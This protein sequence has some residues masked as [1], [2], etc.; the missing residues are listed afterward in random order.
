MK[1][2]QGTGFTRGS[3]GQTCRPR[4]H[5][6]GSYCAIPSYVPRFATAEDCLSKCEAWNDCVCGVAAQVGGTYFCHLFTRFNEPVSAQ[7]CKTVLRHDAFAGAYHPFGKLEC[8]DEFQFGDADNSQVLSTRRNNWKF[9]EGCSATECTGCRTRRSWTQMSAS[10]RKQYIDTILTIRSGSAGT[11]IQTRYNQLI[12]DHK[13]NFNTG[14][15]FA[16]NF[17]AW[18]RWYVLQMENILREVEPCITI[19]F[20]AW[21]MDANNPNLW[22]N[23]YPMWGPNNYELGSVT[24]PEACVPDSPFGPGFTMTDGVSCLT[25]DQANNFGAL[26]DLADI[27]FNLNFYSSPTQFVAF[28]SKING[29]HGA[30]HCNVGGSFCLPNSAE[31]PE[32]FLHHA[33]VDRMWS[34]WQEKGAAFVEAYGSGFNSP[35]I[36]TS[37]K[38]PAE[39]AHLNNQDGGTCVQYEGVVGGLRRNLLGNSHHDYNIVSN[40]VDDL[41]SDLNF[42]KSLSH[43]S[44]LSVEGFR[45]WVLNNLN[46]TQFSPQ[47]RMDIADNEVKQSGLEAYIADR[48]V[49]TT[50]DPQT[51]TSLGCAA[52]TRIA[53]VTCSSVKETLQS[54]P[55]WSSNLQ[56]FQDNLGDLDHYVTP[57]ATLMS[58][59]VCHKDEGHHHVILEECSAHTP[60]SCDRL[61]KSQDGCVA[62]TIDVNSNNGCCMT[63]AATPTV[64]T[65]LDNDCCECYIMDKHL[66]EI[67]TTSGPSCT[68]DSF[69][70]F[71]QSDLQGFC[72]AKEHGFLASSLGSFASCISEIS[73]W[74]DGNCSTGDCSSCVQGFQ[75]AGGC[76][77]MADENCDLDSKI[78]P[79]C[80]Q[81]ALPATQSCGSGCSTDAPNEISITNQGNSDNGLYTLSAYDIM[82][83]KTAYKHFRTMSYLNCCEATGKWG[84]TKYGFTACDADFTYW[85]LD[86]SGCSV[87]DLVD[88]LNAAEQQTTTTPPGCTLTAPNEVSI[89]N[90]GS[91]NGVYSLQEYDVMPGKVAFKHFRTESRLNCCESTGKWGLTKYGFT[92][93]DAS[94]TYWLLDTN[95]CSVC[96][97]VDALNAAEQQTT[98]LAV[99]SQ[100]PVAGCS[101]T[102]PNEVTVSNQWR[103]DNGVYTLQPYDV[104]PGKPAYKHFRTQSFLNCCETTGKWGLTKYGYTAC[105]AEYT[106]WHLDTASCSVCDLN[107]ALNGENQP[108]TQEPA[109]TFTRS[110]V[111]K[112]CRPKHQTSGSYC[113]LPSRAVKLSSAE[114]CLSKCEA[115][116]ECVCGVAVSWK[117]GEYLCN[118]FTDSNDPPSALTCK[119]VL[120]ADAFPGATKPYGKLECGDE[121]KF[122]DDAHYLTQSTRRINWKSKSGCSRDKKIDLQLNTRGMTRSEFTDQ[123]DQLATNLASSLGVKSDQVKLSLEPFN[124]RRILTVENS[125]LIYV[126]IE[127]T[128][129][130]AE[131]IRSKT[132]SPTL[133][134]EGVE[135]EVVQMDVQPLTD[136]VKTDSETS[137]VATEIFVVVALLCLLVGLFGGFGFH[138]LCYTQ[139]EKTLFADDIELPTLKQNGSS[140]TLNA[141]ANDELQKSWQGESMKM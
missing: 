94:F 100:T 70:N 85:L 60:E 66:E 92:A 47:E 51:E 131:T 58:T 103:T 96:D 139:D 128:A 10:D 68:P 3:L 116:E 133:Q 31:H 72:M 34:K 15:H 38:T 76:A 120:R 52:F 65:I 124:K 49:D 71:V 73:T 93:C 87:C 137:G 62:F 26:A 45:E 24:N 119:T 25:R 77:C 28:S 105:D 67:S 88:A 79:N 125:L 40:M 6:S 129:D 33:N 43:T 140:N 81:C 12:Q 91:D 19:P 106:Y 130:E 90:Q 75:A 138:H 59:G 115:W 27:R 53:G 135:F 121:F 101:L 82:P 18:H 35:M 114:E 127:A 2:V 21:E 54:N 41:P 102:A 63:Y 113:A 123:Q 4:S 8:N 98:T 14:I 110:Q 64:E 7:T 80:N 20:W 122:G 39:F 29:F 126:R 36:A 56:A 83:G 44:E 69:I 108:T 57:G 50:Y 112:T 11:D 107:D 17:L 89:T 97:L 48:S 78:P 95:G 84:L 13:A 23:S 55:A 109:P 32:F 42:W 16:G 5:H 132:Q 37:G 1:N 86:T 117:R 141:T 136:D 22:T 134:V 99:A 118:L 46:A 104:M 30:L 61:C 9:T 74:L 111:G